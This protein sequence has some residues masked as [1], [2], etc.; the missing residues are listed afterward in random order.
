M[1]LLCT[2]SSQAVM[3][4]KFKELLE[5]QIDQWAPSLQF[6]NCL[7]SSAIEHY[8]RHNNRLRLPEIPRRSAKP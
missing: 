2:E 6:V 1:S 3:L 5:F 7:K 4:V 8:Y